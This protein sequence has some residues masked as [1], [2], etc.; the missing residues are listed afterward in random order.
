MTWSFLVGGVE[1]VLVVLVVLSV[2][3]PV[4]GVLLSVLEPVAGVAVAG[5]DEPPVAVVGAA[6]AGVVELPQL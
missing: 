4:D 5:V 3:D 6:V 1:D 2:S